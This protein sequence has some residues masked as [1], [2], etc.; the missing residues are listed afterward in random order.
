MPKKQKYVNLF[1]MKRLLGL[2]FVLFATGVFATEVV[3]WHAFD[4]FLGEKFSEIIDEFNAQPGHP[5]VKLV[6]KENYQI[7]YEEGIEAHQNGD[8]P[9]ILQVY[10]VATLSMMLVPIRN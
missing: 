9:H 8:G 1:D 6:C 2:F 3:M 5:Y 7:A 10:E 4:G